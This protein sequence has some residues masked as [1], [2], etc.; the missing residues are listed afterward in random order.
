MKYKRISQLFSLFFLI[1]FISACTGGDEV[2]AWQKINQGAFLVDVRTPSEYQEGH[3]VG[4]TLIPVNQLAS[5]LHEFG[6]DKNRAIVLY[7]K[8]GGRASQAK[9]ILEENGFTDVTN[10]GGYSGMLATKPAK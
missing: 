9:T 5:R 3:L 4:A 8:V 1:G 7:C 2:L 6:D 10:G